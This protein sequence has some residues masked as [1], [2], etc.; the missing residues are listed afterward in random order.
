VEQ[1]PD[2]GH[3]TEGSRRYRIAGA[4]GLVALVAA[5]IGLF[6]VSRGKWSD[7]IIDSGTEWI[8]SDALSRGQLLY[9]DV[10]YWFGPFTPYFLAAFFVPLGSSFRTLAVAGVAGSIGTLCAL[11]FALNRVTRRFDAVLW[12]ALAVPTLVFM[13]NAGG[14]IIGMGYRIWHPATFALIAISLASRRS[15]KRDGWRLA[16]IV[17]SAALAGLSRTDWGILTLVG[18]GCAVALRETFRREFWREV[19]L[20]AVASVALTLAVFGIFVLLAGTDAVLK[21]S[22]LFLVGVPEETRTF[23]IAFSGVR[24]WRE[25]LAQLVYSAAMW[26]GVYLVM[27]VWSSRRDDPGRARR[28]L[29]WFAGLSA[30]LAVS[31]A[32]GG[33]S[34][35]VLFSA[36]PFVCLGAVCCAFL[37]G[38]GPR[39]AAIG[40]FGLFGL[41]AS[42]RRV[43]HIGDSAYVAPPLLFAFISAAALLELAVAH[44]P[45]KVVRD[46]LRKSILIGLG[47]L[48][49]F[50][51]LGRALQYSSDPRVAIPGTAGMLSA[52]PSLSREIVR[53]A[54]A[55]RDGT[56][57][58]DAL[59]VF[60]EGQILNFL[61]ERSNP[62]RQKLY[63]PGYLTADNELALLDE[64]NR[65]RPR[66]IVIWNRR[67]GEYGPGSFG[68]DYATRIYQWM[69][70]NYVESSAPLRGASFVLYLRRAPD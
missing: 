40:G 53:A 66:A 46:Y 43:F 37:R 27:E 21:E 6:L 3:V 65:A 34:G 68:V 20:I 59:V 58:G 51:F 13:P 2:R 25:G 67:T 8:Y 17:A 70:K 54:S 5:S 38:G 22:R 31:A 55:V 62:L 69:R 64:L 41:L 19:S 35:A 33:A 44:E 14:S 61:S 26:G 29:P 39:A 56:R 49:V 47:T 36:A 52:R 10:T 60:P 18:V 23:L 9:R 7:S 28:R 12:T 48:T 63:I 42:H 15:Y 57:P 45:R 4:A 16:A 1:P 32:L 24:D 30:C 11:Y 50:A